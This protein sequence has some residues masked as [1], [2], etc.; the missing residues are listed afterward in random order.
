MSA[1]YVI[2]SSIDAVRIRNICLILW[3]CVQN[4][5][6]TLVKEFPKP[7]QFVNEPFA[8]WPWPLTFL[9]ACVHCMRHKY[10]TN[11]HK[12]GALSIWCAFENS[13]VKGSNGKRICCL[14]Q[15]PGLIPSTEI[16]DCLVLTLQFEFHLDNLI[17]H[18]LVQKAGTLLDFCFVGNSMS[19][20]VN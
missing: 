6:L 11:A 1:S 14:V 13:Q 2:L 20:A 5:Y 18:H 12:S 7:D 3:N 16:P 19:W 10:K 8:L 4:V 9:H 15:Q 17:S